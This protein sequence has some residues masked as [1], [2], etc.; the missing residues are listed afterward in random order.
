MQTTYAAYG[1]TL[2][3]SF[4]LPGM[5]PTD[6]EGLRPLDMDLATP[7]RLA[8]A[9]SGPDGP[10]V[11]R[12]HLGDGSDLTVRRGRSGDLLFTHGDRAS[13]HLDPS[14]R[15]L[16]VGP[17]RA[18]MHW[19]RAL[20]TKVLP[21]ISIVRGYEALH[22]STVNSPWGAVAIAA[23]T[24]MGKTT[25]AAALMRRG[26]PLLSDDVLA[27]AAT[28]EGVL[29]HPGTPHMNVTVGT[30]ADSG[31]E[32]IG[33]TLAVL[34]GEYWIAAHDVA[35]APCPVSAIVLLERSPG[36]PLD[37]QLLPSS[38]LPLAPYMLGLLDDADRER[39]RFELYADLVSSASLARLSCGTA[40]SPEELA[41][42]IGQELSARSVEL[43]PGAT[44]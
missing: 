17:R 39:R 37:L 31:P 32:G 15:S 6:A 29:A 22:A 1:L 27:L 19:Q 30:L 5:A 34:A 25:L 42:L 24:G 14:L 18:S 9:W 26:W 38:P 7:A 33:S 2:R 23:P 41:D 40:N 12:G 13:H 21:S 44:L 4:E 11:W 35:R 16:L 10:P 36:L 8:A 28:P 43:A 20:L 3:C